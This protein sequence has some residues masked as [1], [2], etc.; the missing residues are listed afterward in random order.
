MLLKIDNRNIVAPLTLVDEYNL[1]SVGYMSLRG[2]DFL[3]LDLPLNQLVQAMED[4]A[5]NGKQFL[6]VS[7]GGI[8]AIKAKY[9]PS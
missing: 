3:R 1:V 2:P 6:D 8:Q 7:P 9:T 4:A 5:G